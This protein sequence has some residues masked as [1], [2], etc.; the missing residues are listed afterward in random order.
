MIFGRKPAKNGS[1]GQLVVVRF[2]RCKDTQNIN[3]NCR[4][5]GD[6]IQ[7]FITITEQYTLAALQLLYAGICQSVFPVILWVK[8]EKVYQAIPMIEQTRVKW[9]YI[10]IIYGMDMRLP[11]MHQPNTA[12][13]N[14]C[15][16]EI[17]LKSKNRRLHI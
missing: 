16:S 14:D 15:S 3:T 8:N 12:G 2:Q 6:Y 4:L 9:H 7:Y 11:E 17:P 5:T 10:G 13:R 1:L